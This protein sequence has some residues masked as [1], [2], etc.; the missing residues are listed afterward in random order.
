MTLQEFSLNPKILNLDAV[1]IPATSISLV[2]T[3]DFEKF[4]KAL[5][6]T[7]TFT[8]IIFDFLKPNFF[9]KS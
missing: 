6:K 5:I 8:T 2:S 9:L 7:P 4:L 3:T 1:I